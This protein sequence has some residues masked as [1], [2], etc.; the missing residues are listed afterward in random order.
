VS[1]AALGVT[2][3]DEGPEAGGFS[4]CRG[5]GG[6]HFIFLLSVCRSLT[7]QL[8]PDSHSLT[9]PLPVGWGGE[10]DKRQNSWVEINTV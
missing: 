8:G 2:A 10:M 1:L 9:P 4:K 7:W 3:D 6:K 5:L